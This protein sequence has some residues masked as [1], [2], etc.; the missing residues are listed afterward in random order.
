MPIQISGKDWIATIS[1]YPAPRIGVWV[2]W[3]GGD[4]GGEFLCMRIQP[5]RPSIHET[6]FAWLVG[7]V[8]AWSLIQPKGDGT[9]GAHELIAFLHNNTTTRGVLAGWVLASA[10]PTVLF[11]SEPC[12]FLYISYVVC[13][14]VKLLTWY[15]KLWC[16][17]SFHVTY[18]Q[19]VV[20][21]VV[22]VIH[23]IVVALNQSY[24]LDVFLYGM[25]VW[26]M[27]TTAPSVCAK[28]TKWKQSESKSAVPSNKRQDKA[29]T[30]RLGS[31]TFSPMYFKVK[32][33]DEMFDK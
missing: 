1:I 3:G 29:A 11:P 32:S 14:A 13:E 30:E 4:G 22:N 12:L 9:N 2:E 15:G 18:N 6:F 5:S 10:S 23:L 28:V 25:Q 33:S 21:C 26:L 24:I 19:L 8:P 20:S 7:R 16:G 31:R 17:A 27:S